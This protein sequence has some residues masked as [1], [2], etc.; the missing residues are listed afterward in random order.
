MH[1]FDVFD[2]VTVEPGA[3]DGGVVQ[4]Y[5]GKSQ[6]PEAREQCQL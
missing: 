2:V 5:M 6:R 4:W 3:N 1:A